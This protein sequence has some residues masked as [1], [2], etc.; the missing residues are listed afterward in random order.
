MKSDGSLL[1]ETSLTGVAPGLKFQ[2][3]GDDSSRGDISATYKHANATATAELDVVEFSKVSASILGGNDVFALGVSAAAKL[4]DKADVT[5][6]DVAGS[7]KVNDKLFAGINTTKKF[8]QYNLSLSYAH[9]KKATLG[10]LFTYQPDTSASSVTLGGAY[11]CN[12]NTTVK[13]KVNTDGVISVSVKQSCP[14]KCVVVG[15]VEADSRDFSQVKF[16]A[17]ITLG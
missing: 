8:S 16:G 7:Y 15:A 3:K 1:T 14:S 9:C 13:G 6:L 5:A 4:G 10:G 11:K 2:F 12:P 17:T